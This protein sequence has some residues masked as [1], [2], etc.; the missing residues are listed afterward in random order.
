M[1]VLMFPQ[2]GA[3]LDMFDEEHRTPL[4]A[5]CENNQ[6]NTVQYLLRAGAAVGHKVSR[7]LLAHHPPVL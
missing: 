5:A 6:L 7:H 3:N 1:V 2:A 4:M